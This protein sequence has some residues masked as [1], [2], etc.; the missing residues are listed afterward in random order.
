MDDDVLEK[1]RAIAEKKHT[2]FK[3]IVNEALRTGLKM[4]KD[5][6]PRKPYRTNP[7]KMGIRRGYN[8][9]NIQEL[10][11]QAEGENAR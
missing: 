8:L 4:V 6:R 11:A 9:D 3:T 1:A 2:P 5:A 10:L 7:H